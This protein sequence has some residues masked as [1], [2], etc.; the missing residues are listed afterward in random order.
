MARDIIHDE[1]IQDIP[2]I[3]TGSWKT[4]KPNEINL[5]TG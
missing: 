1:G 5:G 3:P 4:N 2:E